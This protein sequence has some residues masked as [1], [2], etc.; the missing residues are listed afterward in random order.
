MKV[1][2]EDKKT[3]LRPWLFIIM[4]N[5]LKPRGV[6]Q[7]KFVDGLTISESEAKFCRTTIQDSATNIQTWSDTSLFRLHEK[8]KELRIGFKKSESTFAP[9]LINGKSLDVVHRNFSHLKWKS[10]VAKI[11]SKSSKRSHF[12]FC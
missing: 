6:E 1:Q 7:V 8:C 2:Y 10:H 4:I 9:I 3:K 5:N 12:W 11:I